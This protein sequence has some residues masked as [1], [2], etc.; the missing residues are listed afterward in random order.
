MPKNRADVRV[1]DR[2]DHALVKAAD[3]LRASAKSIRSSRSLS[4]IVEGSAT[5]G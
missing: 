3:R 2:L 5:G 1:G 4:E